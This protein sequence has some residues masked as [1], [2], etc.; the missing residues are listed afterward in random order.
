MSDITS[1]EPEGS[2]SADSQLR[3]ELDGRITRVVS[4][5]K[6]PK[7]SG[8]ASA[9][10]GRAL[11]VYRK[12]LSARTEAAEWRHGTLLDGLLKDLSPAEL[13]HYYNGAESL[14][15]ALRIVEGET[16]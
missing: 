15:H 3:V 2:A 11:K 10:V 7:A 5:R 8:K 6:L 14:R 9:A 4:E 13:A 12:M 16:P 1:Y